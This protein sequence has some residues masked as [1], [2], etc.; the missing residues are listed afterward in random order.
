MPHKTP[1]LTHGQVAE[2]LRRADLDP[3]DWDMAG[4]AARTNSWI[5]DNHAELVDS[6]VATWTADLQAQ[7]YDEFGALAAVDFYE[8][9]VI[10]TGP[11]SAP[12][13]ALQDR[14]EAG[15]FDTWEPVWSAPKPTAIQQNSAQE[16]RMDT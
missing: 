13:Q 4:I 10:E 15:E 12:W 16:P 7:H 3:A 6:E 1:K 8:Q 9:C 5:A 2:Q 14:V 11:D